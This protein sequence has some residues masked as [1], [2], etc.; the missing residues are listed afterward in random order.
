[1]ADYNP[2]PLKAF[3]GQRAIPPKYYDFRDINIHEPRITEGNKTVGT[4]IIEE[5]K[6]IK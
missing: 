2:H 3:S 4:G 5:V 6:I 1:L